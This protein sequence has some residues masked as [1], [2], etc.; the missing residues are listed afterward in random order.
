MF[1]ISDIRKY[2]RCPRL[3]WL[4]K[5]GERKERVRYIHLDEAMSILG[6]KKLGI[7]EAFVGKAG[8]STESTLEAMENQE[9]IIKGRFEYQNLRVKIPFMHKNQEKWDI[10]FMHLSTLPK[11]Q[12]IEYYTDNYWVLKNLKVS[13]G[14]IYIIYFNAAYQKNGPLDYQE[15][16]KITEDFYTPKGNPAG[17]IKQIIKENYHSLHSILRRMNKLKE[18]DI[19]T[20]KRTPQCIRRNK[21]PHFEDCFGKEEVLP[22]SSTLF[23]VSSQE[24]Y[25]LYDKGL[26]KMEQINTENMELTKQ[27]Y[28]QIMAARNGGLFIDRMG[29]ATW[30][31][32]KIEYPLSYLD[33]EWDTYAIPPYD[34]MNPFDV[35]VFQYSLHILRDELEHYDYLGMED[36]REEFIRSLLENLPDS[37]SILTF[38]GEGAEKIRL[39]ELMKSFPQYQEQLQ[40]VIDR[41]V[42]ISI[43]FSMGYIYHLKMR[44]NYSLKQIL[45]AVQDVFSYDELGINKAM[46]AVGAW[47]NLD[48][49]TNLDEEESIKQLLEYCSMD[50]YALYIL[51]EWFLQ[52][53]GEE[54]KH[55]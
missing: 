31:N 22:D 37:G 10:Y 28:A 47:R 18:E 32:D 54:T 53:V 3:F 39:Q 25:T 14:K 8:D 44:G 45:P 34:G 46:D 1:H 43:P 29:L 6:A 42:D 36:C 21:C 2:L 33:F 30:I 9:W 19:A 52:E 17:N 49:K 23:L 55:A 26:E 35:V 41:I 48:E 40:K 7:K 27:Q 24:K 50:T 5:N 11:N 12:D 4:E 38:N 20:P 16:L 15:L 51:F 13:I